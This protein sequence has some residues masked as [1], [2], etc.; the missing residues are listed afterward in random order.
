MH[1][2]YK[3][4]ELAAEDR[5]IVEKLLGRT[6]HTD[7]AVEVIAYVVPELAEAE[8]VARSRATARILELAKG[9]PSAD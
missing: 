7:E 5:N 9:K 1:H 3:T 6:L 2:A 4:T 8:A